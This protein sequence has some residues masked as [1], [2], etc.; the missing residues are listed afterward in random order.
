MA[1]YGLLLERQHGATHPQGSGQLESAL[2]ARA[3]RA[4]F[5]FRTDPDAKEAFVLART[6]RITIRLT[7]FLFVLASSI[8]PS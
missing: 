2:E 4:L 5:R 3:P 8:G 6:T 7:S 1:G